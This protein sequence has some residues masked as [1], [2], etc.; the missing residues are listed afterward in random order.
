MLG[1][2]SSL[3]RYT[4]SCYMEFFINLSNFVELWCQDKWQVQCSWDLMKNI[5]SLHSKL[6]QTDSAMETE[7][8]SWW[9]IEPSRWDIFWE[10]L[11]RFGDISKFAQDW[12]L[13]QVQDYSAPDPR[14]CLRAIF[15]SF[16]HVPLC[17][18]T[19]ASP[20]VVS[21]RFGALDSIPH[22]RA[23]RQAGSV[24]SLKNQPSMIPITA[25]ELL[26]S[27]KYFSQKKE[28]YFRKCLIGAIP[29]TCFSSSAFVFQA[30]VS[31]VILRH[32]FTEKGEGCFFPTLIVP[33][34]SS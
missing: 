4:I 12:G 34:W 7:L 20:C 2:K 23:W 18:H 28:K 25:N 13:G 22:T 3:L 30:F 16:P 9:R 10:I 27:L 8:Q 1:E 31:P 19:L 26:C 6:W 33:F 5:K 32:I 21:A 14:P 15:C 24:L 11:K 17:P 29:I